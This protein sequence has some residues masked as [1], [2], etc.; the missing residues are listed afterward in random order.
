[1]AASSTPTSLP[2]IEVP[3]LPSPNL[4]RALQQAAALAGI[5][6]RYWDIWGKQHEAP[7]DVLQALLQMKGI[8]GATVEE[9]DAGTETLFRQEQ[10]AFLPSPLVT[11]QGNATASC[12][13]A[14]DAPVAWTA[15]V[16]QEDGVRFGIAPT[17]T[18]LEK[19]TFQGKLY[20]RYQVNLGEA[21]GL[22][23]HRLHLRAVRPHD[24]VEGE[25]QWIHCPVSAPKLPANK[26]YSGVCV[27]LYGIK[28]S[29][30]WGVGDYTDLK[31]FCDWAWSE[32]GAAFV[33]LNPLH[34][35][36]NRTPY[37]TS[38]YLPATIF[39]RNFLYIDVEAVP[40]FSLSRWANAIRTGRTAMINKLRDS[41][42][43]EYE[44][45][46]KLKRQLLKQLFREFLRLPEDGWRR[47]AFAAYCVEQ[48]DLLH[49]FA[50]YSALDETLHRRDPNCWIWP[51]WPTEYQ[52]PE[53]AAV[54][55]FAAEHPRLVAFYKYLCFVGDEQLAAVQAH[56]K[57]LGMPIGLYH[58]LALAT[59]RCGAD[60]WAHR[61]Y[62]ATGCRVGA[63]PDDFSP[64]GQDWSFPPANETRHRAEG[65]RLFAAAIRNNARHG[66]ALRMDHVMRFFRLYC[67][68]DGKTA[69]QG[70][71]V[72]ERWQDLVRIIALEAN[73]QKVLVIGEDLGTVEPY[74]REALAEAGI[75]SYRLLY[76]ERYGEGHFKKPAEY[77]ALAVVSSTTHDLPTLA[78]FW[79]GRDIESRKSAGL[80]PDDNS[81][82]YQ[83]SARDNDRQR[84]L[85]VM[86]ELGLLPPGYTRDARSLPELT[87]EL[88]NAV[89]G[90]LA[91]TP[92]Q[93]L[94]L[95]QEDLTKETE[96]QNL[97][98]STWQYPNWRRKMRYRLEELWTDL[99]V[100]DFA[101]M[102]RTWLGKTGRWPR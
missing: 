78:G 79:L 60:L 74:I 65:Y 45:V 73:R 41:H 59:D 63:P 1:M 93:L 34:A 15:W 72:R 53:A 28:S 98:G 58:D 67:I 11:V 99:R 23:Y 40:E 94:V 77:P 97:P 100:R 86:H 48:G 96:Q 57:A 50:L 75:F 16:D 46:A 10:L 35:L 32:A 71:Y 7:L 8:T 30:N 37:N 27:S 54:Q 29:R 102:Y 85:E 91:S 25:T 90:Y 82:R 17:V 101:F 19:I 87:G 12:V 33:A 13:V 14:G 64:E 69:K 43:V 2:P 84:M 21:V 24:V 62:Y 56:A 89:I 20:R 42:L 80:L 95:N 52:L 49:R 76:F 36:A 81:Y 83:W 55:E 39:F 44:A 5:Q 31:G 22:G 3:K 18:A 66:G 92:S 4:E 26:K 70:T 61:G 88:H 51:D 6:D 38:P 68:P 47:Q 9:I